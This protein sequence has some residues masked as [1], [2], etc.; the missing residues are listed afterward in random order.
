MCH[1][2]EDVCRVDGIDAWVYDPN[3]VHGDY[4]TVGPKPLVRLHENRYVD[5]NYFTGGGDSS[6]REQKWNVELFKPLSQPPTCSYLPIT[7]HF[8]IMGLYTGMLGEFIERMYSRLVELV[9]FMITPGPLCMK[10]FR[11]TT[12]DSKQS[13]I[14]MEERQERMVNKHQLVD[15]CTKDG[16]SSL[17]I[18]FI[19]TTLTAKAKMDSFRKTSRFYLTGLNN[20]YKEILESHHAYLGLL[21]DHDLHSSTALSDSKAMQKLIHNHNHQKE[22]EAEGDKC[23]CVKRLFFCGFEDA[24]SSEGIQTRQESTQSSM[25]YPVLDVKK[26]GSIKGLYNSDV[27]RG[28]TREQLYR[29]SSKLDRLTREYLIGKK[30]TLI[31]GSN[32]QENTNK[33]K[34]QKDAKYPNFGYTNRTEVQ[35]TETGQKNLRRSLNEANDV[36]NI[37]YVEDN[38]LVNDWRFVGLAQRSDRR[39]WLNHGDAMEACRDRFTNPRDKIMCIEIDVGSEEF[40]N[41]PDLHIAAHAALS[42]LIGIHGAQLGEAL[43]MPTGAL[44][45]EFLPFVA[46]DPGWGEWTRFVDKPTPIGKMFENTDLNHI[47]LPLT[48]SSLMHIPCVASARETCDKAKMLEC[49]VGYPR[50]PSLEWDNRD[51]TV[52]VDAVMDMIEIFVA[53]DFNPTNEPYRRLNQRFPLSGTQSSQQGSK[54]CE[55][56]V[57]T[58]DDK[59]VLYNLHCTKV[60]DPSDDKSAHHFYRP[61]EWIENKTHALLDLPC[62]SWDL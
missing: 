38:D 22:E 13:W 49:L 43:F 28:F 8:V 4:Q 62:P 31:Q 51:F 16:V 26:G 41:K 24:E 29:Q 33:S 30:E 35:S 11:P 57:E 7:N 20:T 3:K 19:A 2:V 55:D 23:T 40:R 42:G 50:R 56:F 12:W 15:E 59:F 61:K 9:H 58:A 6:F 1:Y 14:T 25:T 44:V 39:K 10:P 27:V 32:D 18:K 5:I 37:A 47:G 46:H 52:P 60:S 53:S 21:S 54:H 34:D 17:P 45:A 48:A 36:W